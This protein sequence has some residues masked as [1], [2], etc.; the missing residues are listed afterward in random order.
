MPAS[1]QCKYG[2]LYGGGQKV[3]SGSGN[4]RRKSV[5][6]AGYGGNAEMESDTYRYERRSHIGGQFSGGNA[7]NGV[8]LFSR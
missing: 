7:G 6:V 5:S 1:E 4:L 8:R 3:W 2:W